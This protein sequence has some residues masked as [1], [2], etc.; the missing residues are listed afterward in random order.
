MRTQTRSHIFGR[1]TVSSGGDRTKNI[2]ARI[3]QYAVL[4]VVLGRRDVSEYN[5]EHRT[6]TTTANQRTQDDGEED[7]YARM[8]RL[9]KFFEGLSN[10]TRRDR[11]TVT[12]C[13]IRC[14]TQHPPPLDETDDNAAVTDFAYAGAN[15]NHFNNNQSE[16][17]YFDPMELVD[18]GYRVCIAAAFLKEATGGNEDEDVGRFLPPTDPRELTPGLRALSNSLASLAIKRKQ[19]KFRSTTP[20]GELAKLVDEDDIFEWVE[21]VAPMYGSILP[22]FLHCI[23]FPFKAAPPTRSSFDYPRISQ[24]STVFPMNSTPL[25]FSFGCMSPSLGGEFYRLYTSASDGLSFNRL[26]NAL[27]GY[28][29]PTLLIIQSGKSTFGAF[30]ASPWKESKDFYGNHDC[31]LYRLLPETT[32]VYRPTGG[33]TSSSTRFMYCNSFARSRGFDQQA[34]GIGFGGSTERPR[35]FLDESFDDCRAGSDDLTFEKGLLLAGNGDSSAATATANAMFEIDNLEVWGVGGTE[36][37]KE[38]LKARSRSRDI[39]QANINKARKVDK[40]AFLDDLRSGVIDNKAFAHR[41]QI[42]GRDGTCELH[43]DENDHK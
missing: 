22:T 8:A 13:L 12:R 11:K 3:W 23:F 33:S 24:E 5:D 34:H 7:E 21:Q 29:G 20:S 17:I 18:L 14:C 4:C 10:G 30:T 26:Q 36:V 9:E 42:Q 40:A 2:A 35:L 19:R 16:K 37:V 39:R 31:F 38:S 28:G 15:A 41:A 1:T 25:L 43:G 32:A 27:L 6:T